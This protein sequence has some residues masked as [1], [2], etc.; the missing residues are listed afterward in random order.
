MSDVKPGNGSERTG[1]N[2]LARRD[3]VM[4]RLIA[5]HGP[6]VM[7]RHRNAFV[8]LCRSIISQQISNKAA[9]S[10]CKRFIG[11]YHGRPTP[12]RVAA[13]SPEILRSLGLGTQK[14]SYMISLAEKFLDGTITPRRFDKMTD[15]QIIEEL[16]Q[17]RGIGRWTAEMFLI[18]SLGRPDVFAID[19]LGLRNSICRLYFGGRKASKEEMLSIVEKWKPYRSI[20]SW[21]LWAS[22]DS[23]D[24]W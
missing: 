12:A 16:V 8:L 24:E 20:A 1:E 3:P 19:D 10:I 2:A 18:F 15:E 5:E 21:Y 7:K 9:A 11:Y 17:V 14:G 13:T 6:F 23:S 22:V 4:R